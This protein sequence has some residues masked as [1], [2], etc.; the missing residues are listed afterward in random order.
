LSIA[1]G[2]A[3]GFISYAAL[4]AL[5]GRAREVGWPVYFLAALFVLRFAFT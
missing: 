4:R 2:L 5:S 3:F 1:D